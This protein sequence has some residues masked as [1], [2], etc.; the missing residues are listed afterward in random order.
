MY[1]TEAYIIKTLGEMF[2]DRY[3]RDLFKKNHDE[4][5]ISARIAHWLD[6]K[7]N[8]GQVSGPNCYDCEYTEDYRGKRL[9]MLIK[10]VIMYL[11]ELI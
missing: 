2:K 11:H 5:T 8:K 1:I 3:E 10:M 9:L 4:R 7:E 6:Y